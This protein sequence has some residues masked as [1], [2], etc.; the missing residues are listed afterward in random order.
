M[1]PGPPAPQAGVIIRT[2]LRAPTTRLLY[3]A[4]INPDVEGKIANTLLKLK[5]NGME[6]RTASF[7]VTAL[8]LAPKELSN[9]L[10]AAE[11]HPKALKWVNLYELSIFL[12][13]Q[14]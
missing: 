10:L 2:R 6:E 13:K 12:R 11:A 4:N 9:T 7:A 8:T 1:N 5:N 14:F 3:S